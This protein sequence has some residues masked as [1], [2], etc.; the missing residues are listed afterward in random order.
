M[1][2]LASTIQVFIAIDPVDLRKGFEGL[3]GLVR[4]VMKQDPLSGSLFCFLNRRKDRA[5]ILFW[6]RSG[7][8]IFYKRLER[9]TY[10]LP[11][12]SAAMSLEIDAH[13]NCL[14]YQ[15]GPTL[16]LVVGLGSLCVQY[17]CLRD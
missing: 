11:T 9:G 4:S 14:L 10:K 12:Q 13:G 16:V 8:C 3:S 5:K 7:Y 1:L 2:T 15:V 6:D 17:H